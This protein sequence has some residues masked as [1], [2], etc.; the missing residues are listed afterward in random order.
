MK[1][2]KMENQ[3]PDVD[4]RDFEEVSEELTDPGVEPAPEVPPGMAD[5]TQWDEAPATEGTMAPNVGTQREEN[6]VGEELV[7]DG[8]EAADRDSRLASVDPDYEP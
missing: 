7:Q 2:K 8:V 6:E 3:D 1:P 5:V 4:L